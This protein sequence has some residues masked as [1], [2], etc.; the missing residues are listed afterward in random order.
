MFL[1]ETYKSP[2]QTRK[3]DDGLNLGSFIYF[4]LS[5]EQLFAIKVPGIVLIYA[6]AVEMN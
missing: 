4:F 3:L 2:R 5:D 6:E 1:N